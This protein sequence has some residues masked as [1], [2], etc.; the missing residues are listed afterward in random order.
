MKRG[1]DT[2]L[3]HF[4]SA[5]QLSACLSVLD[6]PT[7]CFEEQFRGLIYGLVIK[8]KLVKSTCQ[9]PCRRVNMLTSFFGR[10]LA[11]TVLQERLRVENRPC[12]QD[13]T[14]G[15]RDQQG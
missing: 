6:I 10:R 12:H 11:R 15:I 5:W 7:S 14:T 9:Q 2:A 4:S 8:R 1:V 13:E 3:A